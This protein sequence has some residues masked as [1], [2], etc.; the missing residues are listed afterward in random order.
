[1]VNNKKSILVIPIVAFALFWIGLASA[2]TLSSGTSIQID[3]VY[4]F[5]VIGDST[6]DLLNITDTNIYLSNFNGALRNDNLTGNGII[7]LLNQSNTLITYNNGTSIPVYGTNQEYNLTLEPNQYVYV[8]T[9]DPSVIK[10]GKLI[11]G[12]DSIIDSFGSVFVWLGIILLIMGCSSVFLI[13][14]GGEIE[15][16]DMIKIIGLIFG[17][18][19]FL[20][21]AIY[22]VSQ[23]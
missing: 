10:D 11:E 23:I 16:E 5:T 22:V 19:L 8:Y 3:E 18:G 7:N 12:K 1:M 21:I 2:V 9:N 20:V 13:F 4:N 14:K 15:I 17:T 6:T